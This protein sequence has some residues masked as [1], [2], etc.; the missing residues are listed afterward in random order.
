M[1]PVSNAFGVFCLSLLKVLQSLA[2]ALHATANLA[3]NRSRSTPDFDTDTF[4]QSLGLDSNK[5]IAQKHPHKLLSQELSFVVTD[6]FNHKFENPLYFHFGG[7][8]KKL[9]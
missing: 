6:C 2:E 5:F 7:L 4:N 9:F 1:G 3:L 8:A